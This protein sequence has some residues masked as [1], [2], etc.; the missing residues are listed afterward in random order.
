MAALGGKEF[1]Q[2]LAMQGKSN[3]WLCCDMCLH[4]EGEAGDNLYVIQSGV[5]EAIKGHGPGE[6]V[7][8]RYED[9]GAFGELALMYNC[10]RAATVRVPEPPLAPCLTVDLFFLEKQSPH[11][12]V[13]IAAWSP[14]SALC[15]HGCAVWPRTFWVVMQGS[16]LR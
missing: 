10:P 5:Y 6:R 8:F 3:D 11:S 12:S 16:C 13:C 1:K 7:L 14:L 9:K 4:R 15:M 2:G